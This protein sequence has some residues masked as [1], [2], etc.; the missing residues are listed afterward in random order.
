MKKIYSK[1]KYLVRISRLTRSKFSFVAA[2]FACVLGVSQA[3]AVVPTDFAKKM[4]LKPSET[5]L[6]K[7]GETAWTDFPVLVRL[8]AEASK[9]LQSANGTDLLFTDENDASLPFEVET[10][11]P[12][13]TTFVWVKV[14]SL[15]SATRL[16]VYFGGSAN[17]G[18]DPTAVWSRYV[19][20]WHFDADA[21]GTTTVAD[22]TGH[23][24]DATTAGDL[25]AGHFQTEECHR[26]RTVAIK[27]NIT[28]HIQRKTGLAD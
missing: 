17:A 9:L 14:P 18:N 1:L 23:A 20:V 21:A 11:N 2:V 8:P 6:A 3:R 10:F 12:N 22:A 16:T 27:R 15:S 7:I 24:L 4:T 13:G 19:G 25:T 5:A 28:Q 26:T